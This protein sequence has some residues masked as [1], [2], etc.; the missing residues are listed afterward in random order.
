MTISYQFTVEERYDRVHSAILYAA[1]MC[2]CSVSAVSGTGFTFKMSPGSG[3]FKIKFIVFFSESNGIT[4]VRITTSGTDR[5]SFHFRVY[6]RFLEA[7]ARA[8]LNIPVVHGDPYIITTMQIGGGTEQR[9]SGKSSPS[10][11]GALAGG[12]LFGDVGAIIGGIGNSAAKWRTKTVLSNSA[13]FLICYSNGMIEEQ[14]VMKGT[15]LYT[16]VMAKLGADPVIQ[17]P[18]KST[19]PE[20]Q[21]RE[22]HTVSQ[23]GRAKNRKNGI[24]LRFLACC[25]AYLVSFI[26]LLFLASFLPEFAEPLATIEALVVL[27]LPAFIAALVCK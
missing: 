19:A 20:F 9:Y 26:A 17:K 14:E 24:F 12:I 18:G 3:C 27:I 23:G 25:L 1:E 21:Y 22:N 4:T 10:L 13:L 2:N 6:D 15:R 5:K 11:G 8:G 16:E 7:L